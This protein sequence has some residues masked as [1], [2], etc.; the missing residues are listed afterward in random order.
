VSRKK[1]H[2]VEFGTTTDTAENNSGGNGTARSVTAPQPASERAVK[3][4]PRR[5]IHTATPSTVRAINRSIILNLIRL[6]QPI[7]RAE[8][9]QRT[10]IFRS[11]I[12][13]I[14][15]ELLEQELVIERRG[16]AVGRGR[17]PM[18]LSLNS[19]GAR[20][21][22]VSVR[23]A[24]TLVA[25]A[26]LTGRIYHSVAFETP[27]RPREFTRTLLATITKFRERYP[28]QGAGLQE[29]GIGVPGLV[30]ASNGQILW[31]P[32]L[33][34]YSGLELPAEIQEH[35][36][37]ST[38]IDNDSN[39][40]ALA[41]LWSNETADLSNFVVVVIGDVG[42][43]AGIVLNR[44][45]YR[46]HDTSFAAEFGHMIV[47]PAGPE[48]SCG[49]RGCWEL[50]VSDRA[51]W[52]RYS[53]ASQQEFSESRFKELLRLAFAGDKRALGALSDTAK[54]L[55]IGLSNIFLALNPEVIIVAGQVVN[56]WDLIQDTV[57]RV[58]R[59]PILN[60]P[61]RAARPDIEQLYL[62]GAVRLALRK[63]FA[64]PKLG[65]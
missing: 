38:A 62:Q 51:T 43:G 52:T 14:V 27:R 11:N 17:V 23:P 40:A 1:T 30:N 59:L 47:D 50:Y 35:C 65:W 60:V 54:Y 64:K 58:F 12:S 7:S 20:V 26:G 24:E 55:S 18:L 36:G 37:I 15:E 56:A 39:L 13:D 31:L 4:Q 34:D 44:E 5:L 25:A 8:L 61:I 9:S 3:A 45:L 28:G 32:E 42:V 48:C 33:P 53:R 63:A 22:A 21:L 41:E 49:R 19:E 57:R 10:G 6:H 29:I 46:G 2:S 16:T